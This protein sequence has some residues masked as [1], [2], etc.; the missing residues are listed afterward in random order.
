MKKIVLL[1]AMMVQTFVA[2]AQTAADTTAYVQKI[3]GINT[4]YEQLMAQYQ[5]LAK[6][7][8]PAKEEIEALEMRAEKLDSVQVAT[9]M[10]IVRNFR[11]T[12]FPARFV[13]NAMYGMSFDELKEAVD[14]TTGF[15]NEKAMEK[16]RMLF[17]ALKLR[18]PGT[19]YHDLEMEDM[20]GKSMKL[21]QWVGKGNYVLVDFWASWCGPC[22]QEMPNVVEAYKRY[23]GKG[24]EIVGVSFDKEKNSWTSAV[25]KLGMTWPQLSDLKGWESKAASVYGIRAIP[26]NVLINPEGKIVAIDLRGAKL[27]STL[28]KIYK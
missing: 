3:N 12:T 28:E 25:G 1:L 23:H 9:T 16:P 6:N 11:N 13:A 18:A 24:L 8:K 5:A 17:S 26:A 15:Y 7:G 21:S 20:S 10:E 14:S 27:Q 4:A 2:G 22:R 19:M